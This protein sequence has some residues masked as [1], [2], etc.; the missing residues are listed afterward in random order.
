MNARGRS[1]DSAPHGQGGGSPPCTHWPPRTKNN[2][3]KQFLFPLLGPQCT[4][5]PDLSVTPYTVMPDVSV[6]HYTVGPY[7]QTLEIHGHI[8]V[9]S[10]KN[11]RLTSKNS[12][13]RGQLG[14]LANLNECYRKVPRERVAR[15][16][17]GFS[18]MH[19]LAST[20]QKQC[21]EAIPISTSGPT[22][23]SDAR[24]MR[25]TLH[26]GP[27]WPNFGNR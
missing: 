3:K 21:L 23:H 2:V 4:V 10:P 20:N 11:N 27:R 22:V 7:G 12:P 16:G 13:H 6:T 17:W 25:H 14:V 18:P 19:Q 9:P 5:M 8:M 1:Q 15:T 26:S 24:F